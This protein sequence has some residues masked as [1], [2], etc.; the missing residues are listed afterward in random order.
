MC[1]TNELA[2]TMTT[3]SK[4][5]LR[6]H[7]RSCTRHGATVSAGVHRWASGAWQVSQHAT[8]SSLMSDDDVSD[9]LSQSVEGVTLQQRSTHVFVLFYFNHALISWQIIRAW[10]RDNTVILKLENKLQD[11]IKRRK[12]FY[13]AFEREKK[14]IIDWST[15]LITNTQ[16]RLRKKMINTMTRRQNIKHRIK[17]GQGI[18]CIISHSIVLQC[19]R[20]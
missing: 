19:F 8:W 9:I 20:L 3:K 16:Q 17:A 12:W 18:I 5:A 11:H 14:R 13:F 4:C 15:A 2:L 10:F 6:F 1:L 7:S